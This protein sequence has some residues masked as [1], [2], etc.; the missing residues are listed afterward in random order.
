MWG[1]ADLFFYRQLEDGPPAVNWIFIRLTPFP[2]HGQQ[3][4]ASV[5]LQR[6]PQLS[7]ILLRP[8]CTPPAPHSHAQ[9]V[10]LIVEGVVLC[11]LSIIYLWILA[12][13]VGLVQTAGRQGKGSSWGRLRGSGCREVDGVLGRCRGLLQY[14][15]CATQSLHRQQGDILLACTTA[16][17]RGLGHNCPTSLVC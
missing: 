17:G 8:S 6:R 12:S 5:A 7:A 11:A 9:L 1:V 2:Q 14:R 16:I 13:Q 15:S 3:C 4:V 10:F